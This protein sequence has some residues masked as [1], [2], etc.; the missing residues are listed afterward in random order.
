[1]RWLALLLLFGCTATSAKKQQSPGGPQEAAR[2]L[3]AAEKAAAGGD[4]EAR[5]RAAWLRY[6]VASDSSEGAESEAWSLCL[7]AEQRD[8][9]LG[10]T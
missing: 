10:S 4:A 9:R 5:A 3:A 1:M 6:L 8:D 2:R 7:R